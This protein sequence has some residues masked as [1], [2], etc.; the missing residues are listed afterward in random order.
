MSE[1]DPEQQPEP[2]PP[3]G[4]PIDRRSA[5]KKAGAGAGLAAG[6]V[7]TSPR[8]EGLTLRASYA[9][10]ASAPGT[11]QVLPADDTTNDQLALTGPGPAHLRYGFAP[12]GA[13]APFPPG[14]NDDGAPTNDDGAA[15][16]NDDVANFAVGHPAFAVW[17]STDC[18]TTIDLAWDPAG[19]PTDLTRTDVPF[20]PSAPAYALNRRTTFQWAAP[21]VPH[22]ITF[23]FTC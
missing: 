19:S 18:A 2:T 8:I 23:H 22:S 16:T 10:A 6:L 11:D 21:K 1:L 14:T 9:A 20:T 7:W 13:D 5:L 4:T 12:V 3:T 17:R 15:P